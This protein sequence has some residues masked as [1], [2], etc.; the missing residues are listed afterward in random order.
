MINLR[1]LVQCNIG[2]SQVTEL[3]KPVLVNKEILIALRTNF[4]MPDMM[5]E[6]LQ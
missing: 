4:D 5:K 6:L 2:Q 3:R 1:R